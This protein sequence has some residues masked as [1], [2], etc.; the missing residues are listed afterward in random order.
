MFIRLCSSFAA[1]LFGVAISAG[2]A[3]AATKLEIKYKVFPAGTEL[4]PATSVAG[5]FKTTAPANVYGSSPSGALLTYEFLFWNVNG[6]TPQTSRKASDSSSGTGRFATAWYL[7][8]GGG[9][10]CKPNCAVATWA[11]STTKDAVI[12]NTTPVASVSPSGLWTSPSTTVSTMTTSSNV[13]VTALAS[14][15]ASVSKYSQKTIF[16]S[17]LELPGTPES[18]KSFSV[19]AD[20]APEAVAFYGTHAGLKPLCPPDCGPHKPHTL[21]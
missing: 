16:E 10:G 3:G 19:G 14:L 7:Q 5:K 1:V 18:G 17:W 9:G 11:F 8:T 2:A 4:L 6:G 15:G 20:T 12:A 13:T 21:Q